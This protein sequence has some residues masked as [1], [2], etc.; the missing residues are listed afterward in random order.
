MLTELDELSRLNL[1]ANRSSRQKRE[2][3]PGPPDFDWRSH[4]AVTEVLDQGFYCSSCWAFSAVGT[5]EAHNFI[6]NG[7]LKKLSEQNLIDCNNNPYT[8]NWGCDVSG[9]FKISS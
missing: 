4:G 5:L 3:P 9:A 2:I 8:G 1:S 7:V 6:K